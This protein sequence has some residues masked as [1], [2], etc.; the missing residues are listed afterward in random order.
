MA[1]IE[2]ILLTL[3][4]RATPALAVPIAILWIGSPAPAQSARQKFDVASI[5]PCSRGTIPPLREGGGLGIMG[6]SPNRV[7]KTCVTVLTLI[8][9]A[10]VIF[11]DG[12]NR[13][14]SSIQMPPIEKAPAWISSDLYTVEATAESA[15]GQPMMLGPM[16]QSL[17]EDRFRLK[18]HRETR[19][20]PAY[21]L[22]V[23]KGGPKLKLNDGSCSVDVPASAVPR[24]PATGRPVAGF[25][26]GRISP[27]KQAGVPCR[28]RLNLNNGPNMLFVASAMT[29]DAFC[30]HLAR[31]TRRTVIDR[32]GL[33]GQFDLRLEYLPD[34]ATPGSAAAD[35]PDASAEIQPGA[36]LFTALEQQLG[37]KLVPVK[38]TR[39][40]IVID[41]IEKPSGN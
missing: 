2:S 14:G 10:Y 20:G 26:S 18:L 3:A 6:P 12:Q 19:S 24:D 28:F 5:H 1:M 9:D 36:S 11:A 40:A 4:R 7:A 31:V 41:H 15:P 17:L 38:G 35:H 29:L 25:S 39:Q 33:S 23:A 8:Q 37:L 30:S 27:P 34:Q 22:T 21:E 16:M 32:T 13:S